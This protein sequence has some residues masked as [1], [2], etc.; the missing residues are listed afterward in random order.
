MSGVARA[1]VRHGREAEKDAPGGKRPQVSQ[2][3]FLGSSLREPGRVCASQGQCVP[4][5]CS[6]GTNEAAVS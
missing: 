1:T 2:T 5:G 3:P 4:V 6:W